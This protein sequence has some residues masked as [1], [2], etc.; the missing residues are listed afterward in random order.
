[1]STPKILLLSRRDIQTRLAAV[2]EFLD[3]CP[4]EMAIASC[5]EDAAEAIKL[6]P[7]VGCFHKLTAIVADYPASL[8]VNEDGSIEPLELQETAYPETPLIQ[9]V[10]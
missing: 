6:T 2:K 7:A 4:L 1:M 9:V 8:I 3:L 5:D 10:Q